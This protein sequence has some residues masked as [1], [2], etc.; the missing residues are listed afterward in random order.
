MDQAVVV[1]ELQ[2]AGRLQ[3]KADRRLRVDL[4]RLTDHAGQ[5]LAGHEFHAEVVGR[6]AVGF[7]DAD[8]VNLH[9][10]VMGQLGGGESFARKPRDKMRIFRQSRSQYFQRHVAIERNL[11][12]QI[13]RAHSAL[14]ELFENLISAEFSLK[15][16]R[17]G[18]DCGIGRR[19]GK[20]RRHSFR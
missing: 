19:L 9:D 11:L 8:I 16:E 4:A 7:V 6:I 12:G 15:R 3:D 18:R 14:A 5:C 2:S 20:L 13:D 1:R 10:V 17:I